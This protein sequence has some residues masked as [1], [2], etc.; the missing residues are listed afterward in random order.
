VYFV[1]ER[2]KA[3]VA[4]AMSDTS[5]MTVTDQAETCMI[6]LDVLEVAEAGSTLTLYCGHRLHSECALRMR[7]FGSSGRCPMCREPDSS[8]TSIQKLFEDAGKLHSLGVYPKA[9]ALLAKILDVDPE[10]APAAHSLAFLYAKGQGIE[11]DLE[12]AKELYERAHHAGCERSTTNLGCMYEN[13]VGVKQDL[14]K[15][16]E[17]YEEAHLLGNALAT[18]NLGYMYLMGRGV[19]QS[20]ERAAMFFDLAHSAGVKNATFNLGYMY[21]KGLGVQQSFS[22][23]KELY[24]DAHEAGILL[25][26][27]N[28]GLMYEHGRG[29]DKD[30]E[31]AKEL[32]HKA[33]GW[34]RA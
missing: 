22:I 32:Y 16:K 33:R 2:Q 28:L 23:A 26:R 30:M 9:A 17:L 8:L 3:A 25:A 21:E 12:K 11:Q 13:G 24:E 19:E 29:V 4:G 1:A 5:I 34:K 10:H 31:K 6:C 15:A 14:A 20:H 18:N 7:R 27:I